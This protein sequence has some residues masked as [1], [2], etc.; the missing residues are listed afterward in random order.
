MFSGL[1][2]QYWITNCCTL[3]QDV[4]PAFSIPKLPVVFRQGLRP[5]DPSPSTVMTS[6]VLCPCS[7][8][9]AV[10]LVRLY[11]CIFRYHLT[12]N[13]LMSWPYNLFA[14]IF[15][16]DSWALDAGVILL[17]YPL[18]PGITWSLFSAFWLVAVFCHCLCLFQGDISLMSG[19]SYA[20][21]YVSV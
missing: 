10:M 13:S 15:Q 3:P 19:E 2:I 12:E 11:K 6:V 9:K 7:A 14:F 5:C 4:S 20:Y 18:G 8:H 1:T 21:L 16:Y 17:I